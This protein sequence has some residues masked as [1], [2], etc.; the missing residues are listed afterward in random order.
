MVLGCGV[1]VGVL[2]AGKGG[3]Q[4]LLIAQSSTLIAAPLCALL[5]F[6]LTSTRGVM[7][8][9]RNRFVTMMIGVAGLAVIAWLSIGLS[10]RLFGGG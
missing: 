3:T 6:G 4:S 7:N 2:A 9:L 5:L 1:A 10:L 8:D